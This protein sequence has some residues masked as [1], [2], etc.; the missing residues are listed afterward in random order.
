MQHASPKPER[1]A[2]DTDR[3]ALLM[4][5]AYVETEC[6]RMGSHEAARHAALAANLVQG[7][8]ASPDCLKPC[9]ALGGVPLH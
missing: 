3:M 6:L 5:L 7:G 1:D 8:D 2:E 9:A 4:M